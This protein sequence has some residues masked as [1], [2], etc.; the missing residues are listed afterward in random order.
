MKKFCLG[1]SVAVALF[2]TGCGFGGPVPGA[3]FTDAVGP[4]NATSVGNSTKEGTSECVS[5]L[6]LVALGDCS[7]E[8]AAEQGK[9]LQIKSVDTKFYTVLGLYTKRTTIVKGN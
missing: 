2:L 9:I 5:Y 6:G 7:I 4:H 8:A 1:L 3:L